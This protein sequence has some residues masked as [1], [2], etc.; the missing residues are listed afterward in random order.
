M[1]G[2]ARPY[3]T[4]LIVLDPDFAPAWAAAAGDRGHVARGAGR[5]RARARGGPGGRRRGQREASRASSRSRSSRSCAGDWLPG[6]DEL[7]PTM[8]LKRKPIAEK[9]AAR[10]RGDVRRQARV[11]R[12]AMPTRAGSRAADR[13]R[14][15]DGHGRRPRLRPGR[16]GAGARGR[17]R[18]RSRSSRYAVTNAE[19]ARVRRR[20]PA[21]S[22][23][24]S[25]SAGRSCS[26]ASC[27]TTSR[28]P[29]AVAG[30]PWWRQ[31]DG[32]D[33]RH[34][35][36]PQSDLDGPRRPSGRAR[37][38]AR[39]AS[40]TARG[41]ARGCRRR[42][43][44]STPR[45]AGSSRRRFPWGDELEPGGEHRMNVFQG[46]FPGDNTGADGF[47]GTAPGRRVRAE[48]LRP[49]QHDRQRL[50]V[51]RATGSTPATTR[52]ALAQTRRAP[53]SGAARVMRGGSYLCHASY[54][55]RY[56]V[57]ARSANTPDSSTGNLGFRVA[58]GSARTAIDRSRHAVEE[59]SVM[60]RKPFNGK[61]E[62]D[63]RD[64][65]PDWDAVPAA[66][67]AG[68][69][70]ERPV[71]RLG[72]RR[73]RHDGRLRRSGRDAEHAPHRRHG[74]ALLELPHDGAVLADARRRC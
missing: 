57:A 11:A 49:A 3:N 23:R 36:G 67:G 68:G 66:E 70:A 45:A 71:H 26:A 31:V 37:L 56:R 64:S 5:R 15:P 46:T 27:P 22:P 41:P 30:A 50:G 19:F 2:D 65:V 25:G 33:W 58:T 16:R 6:G 53:E 62:L 10:D 39:R 60:S 28:R 18:A 35:E 51:V 8:K 12:L 63:I 14:L 42:R 72:R 43:S 34:P 20:R 1:I 59:E 69:R 9:Y 17:G 44:G 13:G 40:R 4:A 61:I 54:C 21:T 47:A 48:R 29:A 73:L 55:N 38:V 24:P 32:A 52:A 7:T 74:R